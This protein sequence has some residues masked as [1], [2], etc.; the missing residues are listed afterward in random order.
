MVVG[1]HRADA[2]PP[3]PEQQAPLSTQCSG[4]GCCPTFIQPVSRLR[5][6]K[7][8]SKRRVRP[9]ILDRRAHVPGVTHPSLGWCNVFVAL[10]QPLRRMRSQRI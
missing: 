7:S 6:T 10:H 2:L 9:V 1:R 8:Y 5:G 3:N 4:P